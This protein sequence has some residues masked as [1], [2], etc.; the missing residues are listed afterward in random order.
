M[1]GIEDDVRHKP[2]QHAY[3]PMLQAIG[4]I[5]DG[6]ASRQKQSQKRTIEHG[7]VI[8]HNED[9]ASLQLGRISHNPNGK[10]AP[11]GKF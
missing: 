6:D 10:Q 5:R 2:H 3:Q 8:G 4:R 11:N 1:P 7:I 9:S